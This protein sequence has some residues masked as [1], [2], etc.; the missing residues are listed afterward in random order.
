MDSVKQKAG[1]SEPKAVVSL[2]EWALAPDQM[3]SFSFLFSVQF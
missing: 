2:V 3:V 1:G